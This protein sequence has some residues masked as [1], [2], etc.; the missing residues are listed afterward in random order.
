VARVL[1]EGHTDSLPA[2]RKYEDNWQL[3]AE[4]ARRVVAFLASKGVTRK[5][6]ASGC[7]DSEPVEAGDG[8]E[9]RRKNRRVEIFIEPAQ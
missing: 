6:V 8:E 1:V 9:A 7:A 3:S 4:R 2:G 5:M